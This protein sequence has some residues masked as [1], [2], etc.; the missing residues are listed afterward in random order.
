MEL[1]T[2]NYGSLYGQKSKHL[3]AEYKRNLWT[4]ISNKLNKNEIPQSSD[5]WM[6]VWTAMDSID[7]DYIIQ[8]DG[9]KNEAL[10]ANSN[11]TDNNSCGKTL[12]IF[13]SIIF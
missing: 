8:S 10:P 12:M 11:N 3:S 1:M 2:V 13:L 7:K 6:N 5:T 4:T 9:I